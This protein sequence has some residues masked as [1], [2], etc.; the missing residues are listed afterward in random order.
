MT[1][2]VCP[3]AFHS[4][5]AY[6]F[7]SSHS[8]LH[9]VRAKA[10]HDPLLSHQILYDAGVG[11]NNDTD[12]EE[13]IRILNTRSFP[14]LQETFEEYQRLAGAPIEDALR[15][16]FDGDMKSGLLAIG[17]RREEVRGRGEDGRREWEGVK[18]EI[19]R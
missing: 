10:T 17:E 16:E 7:K 3:E 9:T 19:W 15:E 12:E 8:C 5:V 18:Q 11:K 14:Q 4:P 6:L 13:F 2:S 1:T